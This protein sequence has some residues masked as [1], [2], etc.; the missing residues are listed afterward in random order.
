MLQKLQIAAALFIA[1]RWLAQLALA[2]LNRRSVLRHADAPA[3]TA[4]GASAVMDGE[5]YARSVAYTLARNRLHQIDVTWDATV[6][7]VLLFSGALPWLH[8][9]MTK[10]LGTSPSAGALFLLAVGALLAVLQLPL[11]WISQFRVEARFGFNTTTVS[12][13]IAD[14]LKGA[15]LA[16]VLGFPLLTLILQTM[17]WTPTWWWLAAWGLVLGFQV[18][19][20]ILAPS[21]LLPLFNRLTPLPEG[22]LKERLLALARRTGFRTAGIQVMDGSRRSR[23][24]NAFFTGIGR[25][26]KIV[27]FDT[28]MAQLSERE[29]EAVLAHEIGHDRRRHI[30]KM[31]LASCALSLVGFSLAALLLQH[32]AWS[33]AFGF[34]AGQRVPGLLLVGLLSGTV[35]FWLSPVMHWWSRRFEF[36]ADNFAAEIMAEPGPLIGALRKLTEKNL[37]N[38]HPHPVFSGF[39]YSHPTLAERERSLQGRN[40][41]P[42]GD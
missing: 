41:A 24:S 42:M 30:R 33:E 31:I 26:R 39:Y 7:A 13:W 4:S 40:R 27:L 18:L 10:A 21:L 12:T 15:A 1:A 32:P 19:T 2:A 38:L 17:V 8:H 3:G 5:T 35:T 11:D 6:L 34:E 23:H 14:R 28:L 20:L 29:L 25:W 36:E 37:S 16:M 22:A 9:E